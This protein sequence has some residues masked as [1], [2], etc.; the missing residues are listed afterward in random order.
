MTSSAPARLQRSPMVGIYLCTS[1][2]TVVACKTRALCTDG[3]IG[4]GGAANLW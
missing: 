2:D 1:S 4:I 3:L